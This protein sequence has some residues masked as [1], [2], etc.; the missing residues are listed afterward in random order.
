MF[1]LGWK[2]SL[3]NLHHNS[4]EFAHSHGSAVG[5]TFGQK[6][7][8]ALNY[9][10]KAKFGASKFN[11]RWITKEKIRRS[12]C[13]RCTGQCARRDMIHFDQGKKIAFFLFFP[14]LP[15][16]SSFQATTIPAFGNPKLIVAFLS[17]FILTNMMILW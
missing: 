1:L 12:C 2:K 8:H 14:F 17:H 15:P 7:Y 9:I 16:W 6:E 3:I 13:K 5:H 11:L 10:K 4:F